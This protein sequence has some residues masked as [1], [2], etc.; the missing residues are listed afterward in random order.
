LYLADYIAAG[1]S[2]FGPADIEMAPRNAQ[3][4]ADAR[5]DALR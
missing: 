2:T 4:L 3:Q 5:R 1:M